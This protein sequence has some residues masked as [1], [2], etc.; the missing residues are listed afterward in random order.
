MPAQITI[1]LLQL[2]HIMNSPLGSAFKRAGNA[3]HPSCTLS[4][5][6][7]EEHGWLGPAAFCDRQHLTFLPFMLEA[8]ILLSDLHDVHPGVLVPPQNT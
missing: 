5:N 7:N 6:I 4:T 2:A 3:Q 8:C 1:N